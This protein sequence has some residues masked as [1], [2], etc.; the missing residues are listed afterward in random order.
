MNKNT[1]LCL[2]IIYKSK[3]F[4]IIE[5]RNHSCSYGV[6]IFS[7]YMFR[8]TYLHV[9]LLKDFPFVGVGRCRRN[10]S[11]FIYISHHIVKAFPFF[12]ICLS[13]FHFLGLVLFLFG[14]FL[15]FFFFIVCFSRFAHNP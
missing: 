12:G 4:F 1:L 11:I 9:F 3:S 15:F 13:F 14:P 6:F 10:I 7:G 5:E 2:Q 8:N